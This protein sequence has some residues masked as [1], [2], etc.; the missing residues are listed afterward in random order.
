M[1][2]SYSANAVLAKSRAMYGKRLKKE[3]YNGLLNCHSEAELVNYLKTHTYYSSAFEAAN[4]AITSQ[5]IEELLRLSVLEKCEAICRYEI[6]VGENF[7][8][9]FIIQTDIKQ[10]LTFIRLLIIGKPEKYLSSLP[11]FFNKHTQLDLYDL[12]KA[13]SYKELLEALNGSPYK[14]IIE[15]YA[16]DYA[17]KGVYIKIEADLNEYQREF[18]LNVVNNSSDKKDREQIHQIANY[19]FDMDTIINIYR[20]IRLEDADTDVIKEYINTDFTNFSQKELNMLIDAPLARDM[21]RLIPNTCYKKDFAKVEYDYLEGAAQKMMYSKFVRGI[22]YYTS[23]T[24]VMFSYIFLLEN[25]V[26]NIIH[27]VEGIKYNIPSEK[28]NAFLIGTD[29]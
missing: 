26:Q 19:K 23:P 10:I 13:R 6:S 11:S 15:P 3:D 5:Q 7:Y 9:Y 17:T 2:V 12:A 27:I 25:E 24:A 8:Q 1:A 4:T 29:S 18:L 21:L 22:R 14:K 28:I 20:L 16:A